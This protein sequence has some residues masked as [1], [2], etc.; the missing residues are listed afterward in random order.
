MISARLASQA[1][2]WSRSRAMPPAANASRA[3]I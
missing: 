3:S 2:T 1:A